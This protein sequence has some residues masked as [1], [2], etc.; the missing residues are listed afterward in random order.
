M[1]TTSNQSSV[2]SDQYRLCREDPSSP[3]SSIAR[4]ATEDHHSSFERKRSFTLIELLVVI[5]IIAILAGMLLP[6]LNKAKQAAQRIQCVNNLKQMHGVLLEYSNMYK[7]ATVPN[8]YNTLYWGHHLLS[9]GAFGRAFK[10]RQD[11]C[12]KMMKCPSFD[13]NKLNASYRRPRLDDG[14]SYVYSISNTVSKSAGTADMLKPARYPKLT[15]V[16]QPSKVGWLGDSLRSY[17]FTYN[18]DYFDKGIAWRH[19]NAS[20]FLYVEG[21]VEQHKLHEFK[22]PVSGSRWYR[23]FFNWFNGKFQ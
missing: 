18:E 7:D 15:N 12:P 11:S 4:R 3:L 21:H 6:A 16:K 22:P 1:N 13:K 20:N 17:Y 23:P 19:A 9:T 8:V 2:I 10:G 14:K 5:A